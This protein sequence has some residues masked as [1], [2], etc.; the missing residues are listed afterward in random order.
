MAISE[1]RKR[2]FPFGNPAAW[3]DR[4]PRELAPYLDE[5]RQLPTGSPGK[6]GYLR[7]GFERRGAKTHLIDLDRRAPLLVQQ[8]L[9]WDEAMPNLPCVFMIS[10]AG[11]ILQ[12]DRNLIEISLA[13]DADAHVTTQSATKIHEM[14]AN[15][16]VQQQHIRLAE[17]AYLEYLPDPMIPHRHARFLTRTHIDIAAS[18]TLLYSEILMAGRKYYG[19]G[20]RYEYDVFSSTVE[21]HRPTGEQ[22]FVEKFVVEPARRPVRQ[23]GVMGPYDVFGNVLLLTPKECAD[24]VFEQVEAELD[25]DQGWAAGVSRLPNDAGLVYKILGME[26]APVRAQIRKFWGIVRKEVTGYD[27]PAEFAWR[28]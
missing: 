27:L 24:A 6:N 19:E 18:A 13:A 16:A 11:G 25:E 23:V 8:A 1:T 14:D 4:I 5:P 2:S 9:Y 10:N 21:A 20:E 26:T 12:G 7:L 17:G 3:C 28:Q 22:L 15:H